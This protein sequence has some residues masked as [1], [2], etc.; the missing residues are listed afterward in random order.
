VVETEFFGSAENLS[1]AGNS[2]KYANI[3]P[4][5]G[6]SLYAFLHNGYAFHRLENYFLQGDDRR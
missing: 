6:G 1:R 4:V 2:E 3:I 5:H